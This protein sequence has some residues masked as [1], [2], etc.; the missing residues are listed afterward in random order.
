[1]RFTMPTLR[2]A[3]SRLAWHAAAGLG[4]ALLD[5]QVMIGAVQAIAR[6]RGDV[7]VGSPHLGETAHFHFHFHFHYRA[8]W[9]ICQ[10]VAGVQGDV[11]GLAVHAVNDQIAAVVLGLFRWLE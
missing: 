9:V 3:S 10:L 1:M 5:R 11:V 4:S 2:R 6:Q 7:L 8:G